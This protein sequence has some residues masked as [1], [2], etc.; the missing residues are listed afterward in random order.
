[1]EMNEITEQNCIFDEGKD[2]ILL[3]KLQYVIIRE[4]YQ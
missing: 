4:T 2:Y 3:N 1:M